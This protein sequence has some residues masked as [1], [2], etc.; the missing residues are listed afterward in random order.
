MFSASKLFM[1][2]KI[3]VVFVFETFMTR[4]DYHYETVL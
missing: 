3:T 1:L 4:M 2:K